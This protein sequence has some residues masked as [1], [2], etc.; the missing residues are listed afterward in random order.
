MGS[1][2]KLAKRALKTKMSVM[3]QVFKLESQLGFIFSL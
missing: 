3:V 2:R 1:Y